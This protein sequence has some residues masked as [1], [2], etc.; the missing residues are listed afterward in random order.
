MVTQCLE[1]NMA[2][3][4]HQDRGLRKPMES[5]AD[6]RNVG[7]AKEDRGQMMSIECQV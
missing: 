2:A 5:M 7:M 1:S 3:G 6:Q 4:V